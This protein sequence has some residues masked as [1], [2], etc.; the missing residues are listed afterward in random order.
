MNTTRTFSLPGVMSRDLSLFTDERGFFAEAFRQDWGDLVDEWIKQANLSFSYPN[1]VRGWHRH[2]RGQVDYFLVLRG[3][4]KICAYD[5]S[6][7]DLVEVVGSQEKPTLIRIP[8]KYWHGTKTISVEP[9]VTM[10]FVNN[11]YD[12]S[13]PDEDRRPWNDREIIPLSITGN[14]KDPR[15]GLPWDWFY[16]PYK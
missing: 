3:A 15:V 9:S 8:G 11:L 4:M 2:V 13:Q 7:R 12:P 5:E 14:K 1:V 10:Y 6:S 16:P